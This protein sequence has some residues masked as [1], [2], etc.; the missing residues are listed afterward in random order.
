MLHSVTLRSFLIFARTVIETFTSAN[1][2]PLGFLVKEGQFWFLW[3]LSKIPDFDEKMDPLTPCSSPALDALEEM[4]HRKKQPFFKPRFINL[5]LEHLKY[6]SNPPG[7]DQATVQLCWRVTLSPPL[8]LLTVN[9][10]AI[11]S[12]ALHFSFWKEAELYCQLIRKLLK[13]PDLTPCTMHFVCSKF[14]LVSAPK[15]QHKEQH[16]CYCLN[17]S[18]KALSLL[19]YESD[20]RLH[21]I[22]YFQFN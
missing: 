6:I 16:F 22:C 14:K 11:T 17:S 10:F 1:A 12:E 3:R 18:S 5:P 19:R 13:F 7:K 9:F 2:I 4:T 15:A 20:T 8:H 21:V